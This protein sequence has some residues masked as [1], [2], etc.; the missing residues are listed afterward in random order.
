[1]VMCIFSYKCVEMGVTIFSI[2]ANIE[3]CKESN[4]ATDDIMTLSYMYMQYAT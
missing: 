1:M 4:D 2:S 3:V